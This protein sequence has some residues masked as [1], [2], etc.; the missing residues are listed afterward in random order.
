MKSLADLALQAVPGGSANPELA[1]C[2]MPARGYGS[3]ELRSINTKDIAHAGFYR[4]VRVLLDR[5]LRAIERTTEQV[6]GER[7]CGRCRLLTAAVLATLAYPVA[8]LISFVV[9]PR[10]LFE[11]CRAPMESIGE[12]L[13]DD[14][15]CPVHE[16]WRGLKQSRLVEELD[17][18]PSILMNVEPAVGFSNLQ[19]LNISH[20]R[21]NRFCGSGEQGLQSLLFLREI[22]V[23]YIRPVYEDDGVLSEPRWA[24]LS[25]V[26]SLEKIVAVFT[27]LFLALSDL[28]SLRNLKELNLSKPCFQVK[29]ALN[30]DGEWK[31]GVIDLDHIRQCSSLSRVTFDRADVANRRFE[32]L[33]P[34]ACPEE[35]RWVNA[36]ALNLMHSKIEKAKSDTMQG[37]TRECTR[38]RRE[39]F[40]EALDRFPPY[41]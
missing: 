16:A 32:L 19:V 21:L 30:D 35:P 2:D 13:L 39:A 22:D 11:R 4:T 14:E 27:S 29:A 34:V 7:R 5:E 18:S 3:F 20:A 10:V 36:I 26:L 12:A 23:S 15:T 37:Y 1:S 38:I 8:A 33:L 31:P 41:H 28:A 40:R 25:R 24:D 9:S 17:F 6:Q